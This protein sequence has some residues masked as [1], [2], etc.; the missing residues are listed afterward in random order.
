MLE[1]YLKLD[2]INLLTPNDLNGKRNIDEKFLE[3][4]INEN[5]LGI[6]PKLKD[7][8]NLAEF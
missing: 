8:K 3:S 2:L 7:F 4:Y 6:N 5:V 1:E